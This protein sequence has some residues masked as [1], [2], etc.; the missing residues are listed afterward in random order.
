MCS[1][2]IVLVGWDKGESTS[3][4]G[5]FDAICRVEIAVV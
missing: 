1:I 3:A 4:I 2:V 5:S